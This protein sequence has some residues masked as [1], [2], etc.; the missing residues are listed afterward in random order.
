MQIA[1]IVGSES[2]IE[3]I[4]RILDNLDVSIPPQP[5]DYGLGQF[6]SVEVD[7]TCIVG[8]ISNTQLINPNFGRAGLRLASQEDSQLFSPDYLHEQ[9]IMISILVLGWLENNFG[10]HKT[11]EEVLSVQS[12]VSTLDSNQIQTFHHSPNGKLSIGYFARIMQANGLMGSTLLDII[13]KKLQDFAS[14]N[15][16]KKLTLLKQHLNWQQTLGNSISNR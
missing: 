10:V 3:Y 13:I 2:H 7:K 9:G 11:P 6:V 12:I 14:E 1:K 8:V 15:E 5:K 16:L 4:A